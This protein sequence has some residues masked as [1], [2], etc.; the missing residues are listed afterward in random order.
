M[1]AGYGLCADGQRE[2][3]AVTARC[4]SN[5]NLVARCLIS[6]RYSVTGRLSPREVIDVGAGAARS[7]PRKM[8]SRNCGLAR[9]DQ[10]TH[11]VISMAALTKPNALLEAQALICERPLRHGHKPGKDPIWLAR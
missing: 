2:T 1:A 9:G 3:G 11:T 10:T 7:Q 5:A 4:H 6:Q 8:A